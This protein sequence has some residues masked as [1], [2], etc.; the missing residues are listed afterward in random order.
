MD[1]RRPVGQVKSVAQRS[2]VRE[3]AGPEYIEYYIELG[4]IRRGRSFAKPRA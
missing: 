2:V 1:A 4:A 3:A